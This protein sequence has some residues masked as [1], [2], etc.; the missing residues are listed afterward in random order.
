MVDDYALLFFLPL[1]R[2]NSMKI[3]RKFKNLSFHYTTPSGHIKCCWRVKL[4]VFGIYFDTTFQALLC[5]KK[6]T[7]SM[8][9][10]HSRL[11]IVNFHAKQR[12]LE[13]LTFKRKNFK[14]SLYFMVTE[15]F[16]TSCTVSYR[17]VVLQVNFQK[18]RNK[19]GQ[20]ATSCYL[21]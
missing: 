18:K 20:M 15:F 8:K 11:M 1:R 14:P 12:I 6:A 5:N 7:G 19:L 2:I 3:V 13:Y 16:T 9:T 4:S 21:C 10:Q 17:S